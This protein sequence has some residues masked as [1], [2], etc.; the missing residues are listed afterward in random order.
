MRQKTE[1]AK[2]QTRKHSTA[3]PAKANLPAR[4]A[5][6]A[7][8][9]EHTTT[10]LLGDV[11][12]LIDQARHRTAQAVNSTLVLLNW[13][14]G[15][16]IRTDILQEKRAE[17]GEEIVSTLSRQL[18]EEYG[19]G[20]TLTAL[21]RMVQFAEKFPDNEI[22]ATLSQQLGWSHFLEIIPLKDDLK[23]DFYAEMCRIERWSVRT[24]RAKIGG[25]LYERT[26]LSKRSDEL[27]KRELATLRDEDRMTPDLVFRDPYILDFLGLPAAYSEKDLENAI[28]RELEKFLLELGTDFTFVARQK[29]MTI[30]KEDFYLDLLFYHRGLRRLI[31]LDLKLDRFSA[32]YFGQMELYLRWLD[33]HERR[34]GEDSPLGLILCSEKDQE[35][36]ELLELDRRGIR[37]SEYLTALPPRTLLEAKLNEAIKLARAEVGGRSEPAKE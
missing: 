10:Q 5:A 28:L 23:R 27:I 14:I 29:R 25:M 8:A 31:A 32:A 20:Y 16:R 33:K 26:A 15:N 3:N 35:Q 7:I 12:S 30:G 34:D 24:L 37:V 17:Y 19:R 22:V 2:K 18:T 21:T 13:H 1:Q 6:Q 11:R 36:I 9:I 4:Q